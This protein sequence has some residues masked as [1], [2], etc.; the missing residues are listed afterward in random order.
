M[1]LAELHDYVSKEVGQHSIVVN[2]KAQN[3]TITASPAMTQT[4]R[5]ISLY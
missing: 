3:P 4:W 1:N 2:S 5:S